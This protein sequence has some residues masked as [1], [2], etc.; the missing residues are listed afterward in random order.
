MNITRDIQTLS[1]FKQNASKLVKQVQETGEPVVLTVNGKPAVVIQD[2]HSYQ[3]M[4]DAEYRDSVAVLKERMEYVKNGGEL[5]P[6]E[7]VFSRISEKY[8]ISFE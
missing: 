2:V 3:Q 5:I 4:A 1:E 6:A 7:E 8:G